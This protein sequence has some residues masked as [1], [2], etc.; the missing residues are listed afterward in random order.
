MSG[1]TKV[2]VLA[3]LD[4]ARDV[5]AETYAKY[6]TKIGPFASQS[7]QSNVEL[8]KAREAVAELIEA[9]RMSAA[10]MHAMIDA[11]D[12]DEFAEGDFQVLDRLNSAL[13]RVGD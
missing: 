5:L 12:D 1:E 6:Q 4:R 10:L 13:A 11:L 7:Q 2:D 9:S 8:R 3:V